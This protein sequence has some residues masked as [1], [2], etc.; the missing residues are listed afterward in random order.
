MGLIGLSDPIREN[1]PE[2][3]AECYRAGIRVIMITGDYPVTATN[4]GR[5]I[6][7][8]NP[9]LYITGQDLETMT[10]EEPW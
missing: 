9:E 6:G 10:E 4:I 3:V 7:V 8:K 1:V 5:E 2:A